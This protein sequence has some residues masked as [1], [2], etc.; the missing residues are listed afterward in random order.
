MIHLERFAYTPMGVFGRLRVH[1]KTGRWYTV[2]RP[3]EDNRPFVS[4]IPEG[5]YEVELGTFAK[6]GGYADYELIDVPDRSAIELHVGNTMRDVVGCIAVGRIL[7]WIDELWAVSDSKKA[8]GE[9]MGA[10]DGAE[11]D[12][13][14]IYRA[15]GG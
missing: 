10:M 13:I 4:C 9:F 7:G 1:G 5:E 2:E 14:L 3:W 8:F 12:S 15:G 11:I 6:G